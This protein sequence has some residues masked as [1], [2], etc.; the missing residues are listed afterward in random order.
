MKEY[1]IGRSYPQTIKIDERHNAVSR[2]HA[3][4]IVQDNG[5]WFLE[6]LNSTCGTFVADAN[7]KWIRVS[8]LRI[9]PS[10]KI[11]LG[12]PTINGFSFTASYV[13]QNLDPAWEDLQFR[14][15]ELREDERKFKRRAKNMG[16][17]QKAAAAFGVL[18]AVAIV[19]AIG[20]KQQELLIN[21]VCMIAA[22][23]VVGFVAD[24]MLSGREELVKRRSKLICPNP[25]CRRPLS[26]R[27][28]EYGECPYCKSYKHN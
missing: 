5:D 17:M 16:W 25:K 21:R 8:R 10:T 27:D 1:Y 15:N 4:I 23:I 26:E 12:P 28:I 13:E 20:D 14:L 19:A 9:T 24:K 11:L 18:V 2:E 3:K 22:P 7:G 6:D